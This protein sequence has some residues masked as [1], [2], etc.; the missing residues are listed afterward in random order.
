MTF[1]NKHCG[2]VCNLHRHKEDRYDYLK[3]Q[4]FCSLEMSELAIHTHVPDPFLYQCLILKKAHRLGISVALLFDN[5]QD[6]DLLDELLWTFDKQSFI[7]HA[8]THSPGFQK[9]AYQL[10]M[11]PAEL[12]PAQMLVLA[13]RN[14][15]QNILQLLEQFPKVIDI[16]GTN[17][18]FLTLG[19]E[20]WK[21]YRRVGIQPVIHD[22]SKNT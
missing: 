9:G 13:T 12:Q 14:V 10:A 11:N 7:P 3:V 6:C 17:D 2:N 5:Q 4:N 16:V 8:Q 19:R 18:P 20:R 15:P 1:C 21:A 22:R